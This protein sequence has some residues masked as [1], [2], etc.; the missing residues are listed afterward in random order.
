MQPTGRGAPTP[1]RA[2]PSRNALRNIGWCGRGLESLQLLRM[3]FGSVR[4]LVVLHCRPQAKAAD[5]PDAF[6]AGGGRLK[7][8]GLYSPRRQ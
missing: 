7:Y 4:S 2:V 3:L 1:A 6:N 8:A 5:A